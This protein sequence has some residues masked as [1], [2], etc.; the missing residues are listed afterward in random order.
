MKKTREAINSES[1]RQALRLTGENVENAL[2]LDRLMRQLAMDFKNGM[3]ADHM[4]ML[5]HFYHEIRAYCCT[6][7]G[8]HMAWTMGGEDAWLFQAK[9]HETA[10]KLRDFVDMKIK[11][12][13]TLLK[14]DGD[15]I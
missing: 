1:A 13:E 11:E 14:Q 2:E 6:I 5:F 10:L 7:L 12:H 15:G 3:E 4:E 8:C 9:L